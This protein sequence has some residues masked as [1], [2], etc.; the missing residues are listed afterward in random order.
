MFYENYKK[1]VHGFQQI[2]LDENSRFFAARYGVKASQKTEMYFNER[3][4]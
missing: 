4:F 2:K 1:I 3:K